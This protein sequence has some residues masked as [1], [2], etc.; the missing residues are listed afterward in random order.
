M[1]HLT[2]TR[3]QSRESTVDAIEPVQLKAAEAYHRDA[4]KGIA[5]LGLDAL[6]RLGAE[7]GDV[8]EISGKEKIC[9]VVWPGNPEDSP[10]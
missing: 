5:R 7:N 2:T 9:A 3:D 1:E 10:T 6:N 8:L 4:G